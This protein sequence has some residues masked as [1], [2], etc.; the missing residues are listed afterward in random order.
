MSETWEDIEGD[1]D[2]ED[3]VERR[4]DT[5]DE[6]GDDNVEMDKLKCS[7]V[8]VIYGHAGRSLQYSATR[9]N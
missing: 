3:E 5:S 2:Q 1:E 4:D 9:H 7:P 8:S 6:E